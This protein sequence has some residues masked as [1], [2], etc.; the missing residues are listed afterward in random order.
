MSIR[1]A[2]VDGWATDIFD[3]VDSFLRGRGMIALSKPSFAASFK[4]DSNSDIETRGSR[5]SPARD[6]FGPVFAQ[7][8]HPL[9]NEV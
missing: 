5:D 2:S 4:R 8:G 3:E 1:S 6:F 9:F 7:Y